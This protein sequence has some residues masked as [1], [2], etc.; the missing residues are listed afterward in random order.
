[1]PADVQFWPGGPLEK[2]SPLV[3]VRFPEPHPGVEVNIAHTVRIAFADEPESETG[4]PEAM[5][6]VLDCVRNAARS[7]RESLIRIG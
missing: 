1:M 5:L 4:P 6:V 3:V 2:E 7:V